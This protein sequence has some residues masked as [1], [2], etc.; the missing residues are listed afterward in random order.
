[1]ASQP[2][3]AVTVIRQSLN[4]LAPELQAALP[5]HVT[6][7]KFSRV[8]MTAIQNDP[9][10]IDAD[11]KSLFGS[12]VKL[13]QMGLLPD[14]R[15]AALVIFNQKAKGGGYEKKVQAM[16]MIAGLLKMV[17]QSG[18]LASIDSHVVYENDKFTYR[19]GVDVVP[20]FEPDWFGDR[21]K[22]IGVYAL[23]TLKD[24][25][26]IPPEI[27]NYEQVE[28]VRSVSK[29]G[30]NEYGPWSQW[31]SEMARKTVLR[32]LSKRLPMSTDLEEAF[33][34]DPSMVIDHQPA[35]RVVENEEQAAPM[36]RLDAIEHQIEA[37]QESHD[38]ETGELFDTP[39]APLWQSMIEAAVT[40]TNLET[41]E[42][43]SAD[44]DENEAQIPLDR[45]AEV[46]DAIDAAR[47]R[48]AK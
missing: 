33:E 27:M 46:Q 11:R 24:G 1:M 41:V 22:P 32:R 5:R 21:G 14:G 35:L 10:L 28:K 23:A 29:A 15:E 38:P 31:W 16:P 9:M 43:V 44:L 7:E 40:A 6:P 45:V 17:R 36:S 2:S 30:N 13:A 39:E 47:A 20:V 37:E 4:Q 19:P 34:S 12:I 48:L 18:E 8:A 25:T 3:N 26:Q 42:A